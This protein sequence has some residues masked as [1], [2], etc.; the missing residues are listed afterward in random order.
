M[1]REHSRSLP[2]QQNAVHILRS[3]QHSLGLHDAH[4][5]HL[6]DLDLTNEHTAQNRRLC[7]LRHWRPVR[8]EPLPIEMTR[9]TTTSACIASVLR[10]VYEIKLVRTKDYTYVKTQ[11]AL[12][13]YAH[14][15]PSLSKPLTNTLP[16]SYLELT[17]GLLCGSFPIL[18]LLYH[19][20]TTLPLQ[21]GRESLHPN[22][23]APGKCHKPVTPSP[24]R[25][26]SDWDE[27]YEP[28]HRGKGAWIE[29]DEPKVPA[30][31]DGKLAAA[32]EGR[33]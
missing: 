7:H 21:S 32:V 27:A 17:C 2:Q 1:G 16:H 20:L 5:S 15:S 9:L 4:R 24:T 33:V 23:H 28:N 3:F 14:P 25:L 18:P 6:P 13:G 11:T 31:D 26:R 10:L 19:H 22:G 30:V 29:M 8:L 12:W